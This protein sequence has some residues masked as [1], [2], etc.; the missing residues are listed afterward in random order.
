VVAEGSR[1]LTNRS[2]DCSNRGFEP[3]RIRDRK[4]VSPSACDLTGKSHIHVRI[5]ESS[6][7]PLYGCRWFGYVWIVMD[8]IQPYQQW[9][10]ILVSPVKESAT[11]KGRLSYGMA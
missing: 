7:Y 1:E 6:T 8:R 4:V 2:L 10:R 5:D 9:V 11:R 3:R